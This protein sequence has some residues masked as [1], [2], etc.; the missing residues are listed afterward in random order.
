MTFYNL[1]ETDVVIEYDKDA[2]ALYIAF[3]VKVLDDFKLA[4]AKDEEKFHIDRTLTLCESP[5]INV[6]EDVD[7]NC[8]GIEVLLP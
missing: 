6:D 5:T 7:G 3:D 2:R 1:P 8:L 4:T